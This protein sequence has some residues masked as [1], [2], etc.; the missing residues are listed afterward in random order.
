M[1]HRRVEETTDKLGYIIARCKGYQLCPDGIPYAD[2]EQSVTAS[3]VETI[4][5]TPHTI[6][7]PGTVQTGIWTT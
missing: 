1:G 4:L 5:T 3:L 2:G 7:R 6:I